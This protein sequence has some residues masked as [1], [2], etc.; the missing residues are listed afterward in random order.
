MDP[1]SGLLRSV[2]LRVLT[3]LRSALD[4]TS[5]LAAWDAAAARRPRG[6]LAHLRT[7]LAVHNAEDLA[8]MDLPWWTYQS[9][10]VVDGFLT[11][12]RGRARVFEFG[13]GA[14]T[15]WLARRAGSVD[16][17]EHVAEWAGRVEALLD[18][19]P[20]LRCRPRIHVPDVPT[21]ASPRTPSGA[22]SGQGLDFTG[23]VSVLAGSEGTFD[24]VLVDGRAREAALR[25][26]LRK[27]APEGMV[28]LDDAQRPRYRAVVDEARRDGWSVRRTHGATPCQP[29]GRETV[30]LRR[31]AAAGHA[32]GGAGAGTATA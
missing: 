7:L 24:L 18:A 20:G 28:L 11:G 26:A 17:V 10:D 13:S 3:S 27:V 32:P 22:P 4:G 2:Y 14:S 5:L 8:R 23:Y 25:A 29:F 9:V 15:V 31:E 16:S 21:S 1:D 19:S 6:R 12:L 30:L